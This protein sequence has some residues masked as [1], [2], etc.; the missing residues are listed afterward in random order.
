MIGNPLSSSIPIWLNRLSRQIYRNLPLPWYFK[1][2]LKDIYLRRPGAWIALTKNTFQ[3]D[4]NPDALPSVAAN[5]CQY[6][7]AQRWILVVGSSVLPTDE[8][9]NAHPVLAILHLLQEMEF[10][11]TFVSDSD[12][13]LH[14]EALEKQGIHFL[15]GLDAAPL[16]LKAEGGKYHHVLLY[17]SVTAFRHLPYVRAYA[18][19]SRV[20]YWMTN[21]Q[22]TIRPADSAFPEDNIELHRFEL[23]NTACADLVLVAAD[24]NEEDNLFG[25]QPETKI[26]LVPS[27]PTLHSDNRTREQ[28]ADIFSAPGTPLLDWSIGS[29]EAKLPTFPRDGE[30]S[31]TTLGSAI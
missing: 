4:R 18:P 1:N 30:R 28:W 6:D 15:H 26:A 24:D 8:D 22:P 2:R 7:Q 16:H 3:L 11:I 14:K 29:N 12:D 23:F 17:G 5:A 19:Y 21:P 31:S 9:N 20:I 27:F 25:V 10:H 13:L